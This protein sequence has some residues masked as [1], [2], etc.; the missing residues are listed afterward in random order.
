MNTQTVYMGIDIG[1]RF[2]KV[3]WQTN[4]DLT[5]HCGS[6]STANFY[7]TFCKP[8]ETGPELTVDFNRLLSA[9]SNT[10]HKNHHVIG[11]A[12]GYGRMA[13]AISGFKQLN[14]VKAHVM[15]A[16]Q[17]TGLQS[18]T[19]LDLGGQD[20]KVV[21][22]LDGAMA[23][24]LLNDKCAASCGRYLENMAAILEL[25]VAQ[26]G[27]Y[28]DNPAPLSSTCAVFTETELIAQMAKGL[29]LEELAAGVNRAI[30]ERIYPMVK[31]LHQP[32]VPLVVGGGVAQ[33]QALITYLKADFDSVLVL[34]DAQ[35]NG[36]LGCLTT[37]L[38]TIPAQS[39]SHALEDYPCSQ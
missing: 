21:A 15:G 1:S 28:S 25:D 31:R 4:E 14:E 3:L 39:I 12:T 33:H 9:F 22:V 16:L 35:Y 27:C 17:Q 24:L 7:K 2:V 18:F 10:L 30:Y 11:T 36:A 8:S 34:P 6:V 13:T 5:R 38:A 19:L 20:V 37:T 26:L 29:S 23:D 32:G